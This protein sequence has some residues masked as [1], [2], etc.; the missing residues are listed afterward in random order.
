M[1]KKT[2]VKFEDWKAPWEV[3]SDGKDVPEADQKVDPARLKKHLYNL[4]A[5]KVRLQDTVDT[6]TGERD[7]AKTKLTEKLRESESDDEKRKRE[8]REAIEAA[9]KEGETAGTSAALAL[10]VA[11]DI[12]GITAK[13][14]KTLARTLRGKDRAELE[15]H[16]KALVEDFGIVSKSEGE[17]EGDEQSP[18][19]RPVRPR[20]SGDPAPNSG[21]LPPADVKTV[22]ELFPRR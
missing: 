2:L 21:D 12:D 6:V 1:S 10:E 4:E 7:E 11:L 14:A 19:R 9:R 3:D 13:Q 8:H 15:S 22:N 17:G 5:D 20:A 16:A 18:A